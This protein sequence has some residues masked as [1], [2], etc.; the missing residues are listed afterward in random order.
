M[1]YSIRQEGE[2]LSLY[3]GSY[4]QSRMLLKDPAEGGLNYTEYFHLAWLFVPTIRRV[5][6]IGLGGGTGPKMFLKYYPAVQVDVAEIDPEIVEVARRSF[7]LPQDER[8]R[9]FV[10][11]GREVVE[12]APPCTY[13]VLYVDAYTVDRRG[14]ALLP[15]QL[16]SW[17]FFQAARRALAPHGC[18]YQNLIGTLNFIRPGLVRA[19]VRTLLEV[20]PTCLTFDVYGSFNTVLYALPQGQHWD[21]PALRRAL[22]EW[23]LPPSGLKERLAPLLETLVSELPSLEEV[24]VLR[25]GD[26]VFFRLME[27]AL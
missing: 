23:N 19:V 18:L 20:F 13:D 15:P 24:P 6:F 11:D 16:A 14:R 27:G 17:E 1:R 26:P 25:D 8:L 9:I 22:R 5:L 21:K 3:F 10:A 7:A 12:E 2:Y 4:R